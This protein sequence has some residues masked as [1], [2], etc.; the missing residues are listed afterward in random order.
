MPYVSRAQQGWAHT[1]AGTKALGG[2][3]KVKEWDRTTAGHYDSLPGHVPVHGSRGSTMNKGYQSREQS[4]AKGGAVLGKESEFLKTPDR[5]REQRKDPNTTQDD[6]GK[7]SSAA[8][9]SGKDKS[10]KAVLPRK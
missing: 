8:N 2:A 4:F 10:E 5:F 3:A 1:P 7:G 6:W 9:P